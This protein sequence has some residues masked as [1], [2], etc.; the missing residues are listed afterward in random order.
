MNHE[1]LK[2]RGSKRGR[3]MKRASYRAAVYYLAHNDD[4]G[5]M[6]LA[7]IRGTIAL[8]LAAEL[9]GLETERVAKDVIALREKR[10]A[11]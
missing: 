9:F 2:G 4:P 1:D 3:R 10:D 8:G 6:D 5:V 11:P 7:D